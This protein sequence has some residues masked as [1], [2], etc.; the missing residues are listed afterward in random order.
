LFNGFLLRGFSQKAQTQFPGKRVEA[1]SAMLE[2]ESCNTRDKNWAI[3]ALGQLDDPGAIPILEKYYTGTKG[4]NPH[5][6][7][8]D[9]LQVELRHLRHQ[10]NYRYWSIFSHWMLPDE[11]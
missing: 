5:N 4:D 6:L 11:R 10:D 7:D 9:K 3:W 2:C 1:L 8:Q